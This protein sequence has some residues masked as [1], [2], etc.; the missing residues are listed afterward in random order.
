MV[1]ILEGV[2]DMVKKGES[3]AYSF[4]EKLE[5]LCVVWGETSNEV[6]AASNNLRIVRQFVNALSPRDAEGDA[7]MAD[8][9]SVG[10]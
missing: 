3:E 7:I 1:A 10:I 6:R 4:K 8:E 5:D 2:R 9:N